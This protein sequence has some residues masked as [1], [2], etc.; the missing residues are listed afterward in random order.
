[1]WNFRKREARAE[2]DVGKI[3]NIMN[4]LLLFWINIQKT[5]DLW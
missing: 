1:M 5:T 4:I 3:K 2:G